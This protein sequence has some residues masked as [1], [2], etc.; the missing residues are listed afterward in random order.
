MISKQYQEDVNDIYKDAL[1]QRNKAF[2][3][4]F[5]HLN[6][7]NYFYKVDQAVVDLDLDKDVINELIE[8]YVKQ[9]ISEEVRFINILNKLKHDKVNGNELDYKELRELAH[10]N[11]GVARNLRIVDAEAFLT[12]LMKEDNLDYLQQSLSALILSAIILKPSVAYMT[13]IND[14]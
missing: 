1:I 9:I 2:T 3:L 14:L 11:L 5:R 8:D 6:L 13:M 7:Q 12:I 10:K 4:E